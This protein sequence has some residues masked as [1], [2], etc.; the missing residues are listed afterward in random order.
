MKEIELK[1][2]IIS[3][4]GTGGHIFPALSIANE[5]QRRYPNCRILFV[6]AHGRMEAE[7]VPEAGYEI[8]LLPVEG[9]SRG[10]NP[11]RH[12]R[13]LWKL[14]KSTRQV[15]K[16]LKVMKPQIAIGVGG[17]ASAP[18][19]IEAAKQGIPTLVQEQNSYAGKTNKLVGKRAEAICV[20]Y[21]GMERFFPN[22]KILLTGNP[23]R[24]GLLDTPKKLPLAYEYFGFDPNKRTLLIIGGSLGA[25]TINSSVINALSEIASMEREV[26]MIW[27]C[28]KFY[29][30]EAQ[31]I[32]SQ[33]G[34][35]GR[36]ILL[37]DFISH[38]EYAYSIADLVI[39][40]AGASSISELCLLGMPSILVPSPN[41]AEDHQT[42]NA[43]ALVQEN[44]AIMVADKDAEKLLMEKALELIT[45]KAA[46]N[47][48]SE[49]VLKL[50][51]PDSAKKIV[52]EVERIITE[53]SAE[54]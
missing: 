23:V 1:Q 36:N 25:K 20:A 29:I 33:K 40:R 27:Q 11:F 46:L 24:N 44:A 3:G 45:D 4:G 30:D 15:R 14:L 21:K 43:E 12:I 22:K 51:L 9:L 18:T 8:M 42:R 16:Q 50:A 48:L 41:V 32:L 28:G 39:S 49:N 6:G 17:Y 38:M 7:R 13:T 5:I 52:D 31:R 47:D 10:K 37:T 54:K 2:V 26:Q 53:R 19:L 34:L 35:D